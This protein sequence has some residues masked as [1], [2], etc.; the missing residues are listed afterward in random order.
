MSLLNTTRHLDRETKIYLLII[1][2]FLVLGGITMVYPFLIMIS[3]SFKS[4]VD[5]YQFDAVPAYF[6]SDTVLFTKYLEAKYNEGIAT[7]NMCNRENEYAFKQIQPPAKIHEKKIADWQEFLATARLPLDYSSL[8]F[9][10]SLNNRMLPEM[11]RKYRDWM[12]KKY[13]G[14]IEL[15]DKKYGDRAVSWLSL[16]YPI[17][18]PPGSSL[19]QAAKEFQAQQPLG[20]YFLPS[21]DGFYIQGFLQYKYGTKIE[22][23]NKAHSTHYQSYDEIYL[24]RT[25]PAKGKVQTEW[26]EFVKEL[27]STAIFGNSTQFLRVSQ[28]AK[29]EFSRYL[30]ARYE[31]KLALLN[32][33]Y[34]SHYQKFSAVPFPQDVLAP[35][36]QLVDWKLF[37]NSVSP[38]YLSLT[39]PDFLWRNFLKRKYGD[40]LSRL[41]QA[42]GETY[43]S[44]G[45]IP[46]PTQEA[47]YQDMLGR[48]RALR[49]EFMT[50]N[51]RYVFDYLLFHGRAV[52]NTFVFCILAIVIV[53]IVNPLAAYAM[54]RFSL[55]STYKILLFLLA[56]M[57]FPA[58]VTLI[59]NFLLLKELN[60]LNTFWALVLPGMTNG[61]SIFLLKGYFDSLPREIYEA[62]QIDGAGEWVM[63]WNLTMNLSKP[64]LGVIALSVFTGAYGAFMFAFT[65]CQ[66]QSMWTISVWLYQMQQ[67]NVHQSVI[68]AALLV[69][70]MPTFVVFILC[71]RII[72]RGIVIPIEK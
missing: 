15:Y 13:D 45:K 47:D 31:G 57:A 44:F 46:L 24:P 1:Y 40:R 5:V 10:S 58:M 37:I 14:S 43:A 53:L 70:S 23:Y 3:G 29:P 6:F 33:S 54:S 60:L 50:R 18:A 41:N 9:S 51:Y 69:A 61:F 59:P 27:G 39:G 35:S 2:I 71:Q 48:S 7:Y 26:L 17:A 34:A 52:W 67:Y 20:D 62:A 38:K 42:H 66:D 12:E 36:N 25:A 30:S 11:G 28:E 22:N 8:G 4:D 49:W 32:K 56:P 64:I 16:H 19:Y 21:L 63:F 72:I 55:P 68:F 65:V